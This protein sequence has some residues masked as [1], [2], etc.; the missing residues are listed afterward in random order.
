M[1]RKRDYYEVLGVPRNASDDDLKKAYRKLALRWHPDKNPD[2]KA[3]AEVRFKEISEAFQVLS[4][5]NKREVYDRYGHQVGSPPVPLP[6]AAMPVAYIY[7]D[8]HV[9]RRPTSLRPQRVLN[10]AVTTTVN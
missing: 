2:N 3:G 8:W 6:G 5:G 1:G 9:L 10:A 7:G 4:D